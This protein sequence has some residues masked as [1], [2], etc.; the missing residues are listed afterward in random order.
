MAAMA[1]AVRLGTY[2]GV[3]L[4]SPLIRL[5]K[6]EIVRR[7]VELGVDLSRT[8]SC[9]K[10][11][12]VHCGR[13][14]TCV[15]RREAFHL[16][17]VTDPKKAFSLVELSDQYAYQQPL[18]A[19]GLGLADEGKGGAWL[20]DG[21]NEAMNVNCSGGML[22]GNPLIL[23]GLARVA[24]AALQLWGKAGDNQVPAPKSAVVQGLTG[25][26]GQFQSVLVLES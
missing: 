13:C 2:A 20:L 26:A 12:E 8:W 25:P 24:E 6:T 16:A 15:E 9:Y 17:G 19:E 11:G 22:G 10:G 21:G 14:G 7:G 5:T 1:R 23:G 3:E 4:L 18:W